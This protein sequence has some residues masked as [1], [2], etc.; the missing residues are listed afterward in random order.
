MKTFDAIFV[1]PRGLMHEV[2]G[3]VITGL[4]HGEDFCGHA[5]IRFPDVDGVPKMIE[6]VTAGVGFVPYDKYDGEPCMAVLTIEVTDEQY[7]AMVEEAKRIDEGDYG[8]GYK[9]C[10]AGGIADN[11]GETIGEAIS[12]ILH[13]DGNSMDCSEVYVRV[14]RK[15]LPRFL[16]DFDANAVTP[17]RAFKNTLIQGVAGNL[18][19]TA[20]SYP[21]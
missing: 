20:V 13:C 17:E 6:A 15:A 4:T 11:A 9:E 21:E 16:V 7:S 8:Y 1:T 10:I 19:I 5:A 14:L 2:A 3:A 12:F 18:K